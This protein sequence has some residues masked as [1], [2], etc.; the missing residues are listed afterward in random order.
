MTKGK[1]VPVPFPFDALSA[2][3]LRPGVCLC[4]PIGEHRHVVLALVTSRIPEELLD[5]DV[6]P[7][8]EGPQSAG[9]GLRVESTTMAA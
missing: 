4:N 7:P 1:V 2:S 8:G 3:K 6:I 5:S 9:L